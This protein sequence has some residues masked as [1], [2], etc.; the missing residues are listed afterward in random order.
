VQSV[1]FPCGGAIGDLVDVE[2]TEDGPNSLR[3]VSP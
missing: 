3:G 1:H 2:L